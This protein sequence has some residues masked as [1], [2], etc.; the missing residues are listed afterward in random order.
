MIVASCDNG[1]DPLAGLLVPEHK[2]I[3]ELDGELYD[4]PAAAPDTLVAVDF[5]DN[6]TGQPLPVA[7]GEVTGDG[8]A[9]IVGGKV[10]TMSEDD[11]EDLIALTGTKRELYGEINGTKYYYEYSYAVSGAPAGFTKMLQRKINS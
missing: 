6:A 5:V 2:Y 7:T 10:V 1:N 9:D 11:A 4:G 3:G 8:K